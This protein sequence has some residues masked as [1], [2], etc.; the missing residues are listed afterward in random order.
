MHARCFI[1]TPC[2][3]TT[4]RPRFSGGADLLIISTPPSDF[5]TPTGIGIAIGKHGYLPR[6][7]SVE[8]DLHA[9]RE[10]RA[11]LRS[12]RANLSTIS[13]SSGG[14]NG[15]AL[16]LCIR[17]TS[18]NVKRELNPRSRPSRRSDA[19]ATIARR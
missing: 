13:S 11:I 9:Y 5:R 16:P 8:T 18:S 3:G 19:L 1:D 6:V 15:N 12:A 17:N 14:K 10:E 2:V 4:R 7:T